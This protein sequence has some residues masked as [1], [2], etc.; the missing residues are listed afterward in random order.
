MAS[1][2]FYN[3]YVSAS[4]YDPVKGVNYPLWSNVDA[5]VLDAA[6]VRPEL[7]AL[8][9]LK[10]LT[11]TLD[12]GPIPVLAATLE[13]PYREGIAF[14]DSELIEW[15][16]SHLRA[17]FGYTGGTSNDMVLSPIFSGII[18]KPAVAIS[19]EQV[20]ITYNAQGLGGY[21]A[22]RQ[23]TGYN[24]E[25]DGGPQTRDKIIRRILS[26]A[27]ASNP[28]DLEPDFERLELLQRSQPGV[29]D[30]LAQALKNTQLAKL[31]AFGAS[32]AVNAYDAMFS[33]PVSYN[34]GSRT[35]WWA[36]WE[37]V[38]QCR[39]TMT[40]VG[41]KLIVIPM[42]LQF[43]TQPVRELRLGS[44]PA[45][46]FGPSTGV[47][48]LEEFTTQAVHQYMP[49]A[50]RGIALKDVDSATRSEV[51]LFL[52]DDEVRPTR[53]GEGKAVPEVS[54]DY[55]GA[56][57]EEGRGGDMLPGSPV[58]P[59]VVQMA[60]A[61]YDA[62]TQNMGLRGTAR[63]MGDPFLTPGDVVSIRGMGRRIDANYA[64]QKAIH[65][66]GSSGYTMELEL[67]SN[68][69]QLVRQIQSTASV[70]LEPAGAVNT[71]AV[72]ESSAESVAV[73][74]PNPN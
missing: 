66:S 31:E 41:S 28:R 38:R 6:G 26:G 44:F 33:Q 32:L 53:T 10:E 5:A 11:V 4:I 59:A 14:L 46:Q 37:V 16:Q 68:V 55:P 61:E 73:P 17:Q 18:M 36:V 12:L 48:P 29:L 45:G 3:P 65:R 69:G 35:D 20:S 30:T 51:E 40:L 49:G 42:N 22:V 7:R 43:S 57:A 74:P 25:Q 63:T 24:T 1:F 23:K 47:L 54:P 8:S 21:S 2:D 56:N 71:E 60:Q 15:G 19:G 64:I 13:M 62:F 70:Q 50:L 72:E 67:I 34:Q 27:D 52:G 39:C 9:Y 58:D